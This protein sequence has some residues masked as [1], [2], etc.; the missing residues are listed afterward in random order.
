[1]HG[2]MTEQFMDILVK[3]VG[4]DIESDFSNEVK[5]FAV[6][7]LSTLM[8]IFPSLVNGLVNAGLV[9]GL[10][11]ALQ[12]CGDLVELA[13]ACIKAYEKVVVE[14]PPAVLR[15]GAVPGMLG[16]MP[17]FEL[18]TQ[19]RIFRIIQKIARHSTTEGDFETHILPILPFIADSL[20]LNPGQGDQKRVEDVSKIV[21]EVQ[22]SFC[23]F[24][25]PSA[26]F[27]KVGQQFDKLLE[28]GVFEIIMDHVH[29]Y[30]DTS[31]KL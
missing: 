24:Y 22:E 8:D 15:S 29:Q 11:T 5:L 9:K 12:G 23:I 13:E 27:Q 2:F 28:T 26:D 19:N 17:F 18:A 6:Q 16:Q 21:C 4:R 10:T 25:S 7:C 30:S 31:V 1:M 20:R 3:I 14:N